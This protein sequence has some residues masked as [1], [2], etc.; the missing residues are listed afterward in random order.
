M[1]GPAC[2]LA[3]HLNP[4]HRKTDN[5]I[6]MPRRHSAA[7]SP[8]MRQS[9]TYI[10]H[11][12]PNAVKNWTIS[13]ERALANG[14]ASDRPSGS[15][16]WPRYGPV[17]VEPRAAMCR[18]HASD[19]LPW[20]RQRVDTRGS[21]TITYFCRR[22]WRGRL[23]KYLLRSVV[24]MNALRR[25]PSRCTADEMAGILN[26]HRGSESFTFDLVR[27]KTVRTGY[28]TP[29]ARHSRR[30]AERTTQWRAETTA[31]SGLDHEPGVRQFTSSSLRKYSAI[32]IHSSQH[33]GPFATSVGAGS[34][35]S[36][37]SKPT[38][39]SSTIARW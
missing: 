10:V 28:S 7:V 32:A 26:R 31:P 34:G 36:G 23:G 22:G 5:A 21:F 9:S 20:P 16:V 29:V 35:L 11:S 12:T 27:S 24:P 1:A 33:D 39:M 17:R 13:P 8:M 6:S 2:F 25:R 30:S 38:R 19:G 14:G 37:G 18:F 3:L 4:S 15:P